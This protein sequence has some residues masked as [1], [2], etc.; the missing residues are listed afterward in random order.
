ML[1]PPHTK[2]WLHCSLMPQGFHQEQWQSEPPEPTLSCIHTCT[3]TCEGPVSGFVM[4]DVAVAGVQ[5]PTALRL[6]SILMAVF[7]S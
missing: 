1:Q 5:H 4:K 6:A 7:I 3:G 2:G